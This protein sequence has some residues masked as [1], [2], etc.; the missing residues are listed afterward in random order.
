MKELQ[1]IAVIGGGGRTGQYLVNQLIEKGY[2]LKLLLRHPEN[3]T[4]QSPLIEIVEGDV[5]NP[6][7]VRILLEDC[8]AVLSTAGQRQDE[9]LVASQASVNIMNA[10]GDRPVRYV[11]LAGLN[12]DTPSDEKGEQSVKATEWMRATFPAI[13]N[14]RQ[15]SYSVLAESNAEWIMVRVPY[16]EFNGNR[17]EVKVSGTDSPGAKIDAADIAGF[18]INQITDDTWLRKAPFISN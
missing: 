8:S 6:E 1:K 4:M 2:S 10:I 7:A 5:L 16:I 15:K 17:A 3:F 18:M 11:V 13:H 12:V 14:D 9:P